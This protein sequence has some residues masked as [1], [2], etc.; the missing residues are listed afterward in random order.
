MSVI[1]AS[2]PARGAARTL[3]T[4]AGL[5]LAGLMTVAPRMAWRRAAG[6][7]AITG[8]AANSRAALGGALAALPRSSSSCF[9]TLPGNAAAGTNAGS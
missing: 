2:T 4:K 9:T 5:A 7:T 6:P 8:P 3:S 1:A